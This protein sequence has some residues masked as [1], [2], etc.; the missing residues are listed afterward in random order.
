MATAKSTI[1]FKNVDSFRQTPV[2]RDVLLASPA[3]FF[4]LPSTRTRLQDASV[5][6]I[7]SRLDHLRREDE[8]LALAAG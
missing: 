7:R 5:P 2:G 4:Q 8:L 6:L 3:R 1:I